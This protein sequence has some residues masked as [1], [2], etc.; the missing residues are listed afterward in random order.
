[1]AEDRKT[2]LDEWSL[3][4]YLDDVL[5]DDDRESL[6]LHLAECD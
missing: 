1:M 3:Q 6:E 5:V 2:H 4:E